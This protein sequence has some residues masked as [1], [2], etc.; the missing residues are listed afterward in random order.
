MQV[1]RILLAMH[2]FRKCFLMRGAVHLD[3]RILLIPVKFGGIQV[4]ME[5]PWFIVNIHPG[6][7]VEQAMWVQRSKISMH[8]RPQRVIFMFQVACVSPILTS[9]LGQGRTAPRGP[10]VL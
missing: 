6:Q 3:L 2:V 9:A 5:L 7:T 10:F 1:L 4:Q 8:A